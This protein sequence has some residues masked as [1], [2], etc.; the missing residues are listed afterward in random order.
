MMYFSAYF[1]HP[2]Y[3]KLTHKPSA[4]VSQNVIGNELYY[5]LYCKYIE[6]ERKRFFD[7]LF[8]I[9]NLTRCN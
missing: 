4:Q 5:L 7:V 2:S 3:Y 8:F 6:S 9:E 1:D